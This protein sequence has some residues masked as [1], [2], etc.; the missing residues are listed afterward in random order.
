MDSVPF[1]PRRISREFRAFCKRHVLPDLKI[2][3]YNKHRKRKDT[4]QAVHALVETG[5][6]DKVVADSRN[7]AYAV[8]RRRA[9]I[10]DS[11]VEAGFSRKCL[12]S[13]ESGK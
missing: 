6:V 13:E 9:E 1:A 3:G 10:W 7:T 8:S 2:N 4:M 5:L 11:L 12:G